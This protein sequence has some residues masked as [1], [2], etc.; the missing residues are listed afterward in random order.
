MLS[1]DSNYLSSWRR[2]P[3]SPY[4][5]HSILSGRLCWG[6]HPSSRICWQRYFSSAHWQDGLFMRPVPCFARRLASAY[7]LRLHP[8]CRMAAEQSHRCHD[9]H[10]GLCSDLTSS[11]SLFSLT[12]AFH[13]AEARICAPGNERL[14][15]IRTQFHRIVRIGEPDGKQEFYRKHQ[16]MKVPHHHSM[17]AQFQ[18]DSIGAF[19]SK[20]AS[21]G[22][23]APAYPDPGSPGHC[24]TSTL[25]QR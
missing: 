8:H 15:A 2:F 13:R 11:L 18:S 9:L 14:P 23:K 24:S 21:L 25:R 19:P 10:S 20:Q 12:P 6:C 1:T 3:S 22:G 5:W 7:S 17:V 4:C 16:R